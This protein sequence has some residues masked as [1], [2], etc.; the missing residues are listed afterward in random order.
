MRVATVRGVTLSLAG[1]WLGGSM[2]TRVR[3]AT[4][5]GVTA[6]PAAGWVP[7]GFIR[8]RVATVRGVTPAGIQSYSQACIQPGRHTALHGQVYSPIVRQAYCLLARQQ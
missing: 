1:C 2:I 7:I 3:V 8:V 6:R 5:R 4:V